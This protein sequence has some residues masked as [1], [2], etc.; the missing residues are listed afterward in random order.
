MLAFITGAS[1]GIGRD[2]ARYLYK[3]GYDIIITARNEE[4]LQ[5]LKQELEK[6][7]KIEDKNE[8]RRK[9]RIKRIKRIIKWTSIIVIIAGGTTFAMIS[10]IFNIQDIKVLENAE[11]S[12][13][14]IISFKTYSDF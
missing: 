4:A 2:M 3:L 5:I 10:P 14:T 1:S 9:K 11:V 13:D 12:A 6:T 7:K 8:R